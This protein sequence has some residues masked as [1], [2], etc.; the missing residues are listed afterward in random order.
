MYPNDGVWLPGSCGPRVVASSGI[1]TAAPGTS[2]LYIEFGLRRDEAFDAPTLERSALE[3][4]F[5]EG[6]LE[7]SDPVPVRDWVRI[8]PGYVIFDRARQ[9]AMAR[10]VPELERCGVHLIPFQFGLHQ[11]SRWCDEHLQPFNRGMLNLCLLA[12]KR[13]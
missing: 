6:I 7:R 11:L 1:D 2:S 9:A 13:L 8:D 4:L 5:A 12:R 3:A 10:L